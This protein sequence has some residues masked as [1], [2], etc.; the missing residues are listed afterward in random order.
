[1]MYTLLLTIKR[2][3]LNPEHWLQEYLEAC[4]IHGGAPPDLAPFLPWDMTEERRQHLS[5]PQPA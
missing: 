1:M 3:G 4:A 2:W 5:K